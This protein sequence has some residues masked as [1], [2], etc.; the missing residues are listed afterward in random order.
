MVIFHSY[1][2]L[3]EGSI[4]DYLCTYYAC[5]LYRQETKIEPHATDGLL[6]GNDMSTYPNG[7]M[8]NG[9]LTGY[10]WIIPS[11]NLT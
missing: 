11:G 6:R 7:L 3:P 4:Y 2:K 1:V 9:D 8:G 10:E 5:R